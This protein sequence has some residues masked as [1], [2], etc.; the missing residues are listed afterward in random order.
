MCYSSQI[1]NIATVKSLNRN[2]EFFLRKW[3]HA[4]FNLPSPSSLAQI[5]SEKRK[6]KVSL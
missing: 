2:L 4:S 6:L 3:C 1:L 5:L